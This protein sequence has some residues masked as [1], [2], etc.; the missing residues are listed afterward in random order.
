MVTNQVRAQSNNRAFCYPFQGALCFDVVILCNHF[1][2]TSM[3]H[4]PIC[5]V[6]NRDET[7]KN[8]ERFD[9]HLVAALGI[10]WAHAVTIRLVLEAHS[11]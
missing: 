6:Q 1:L 2:R 3:Q 7:V 8:P 10:N 4:V 11:G 5:A 9:S